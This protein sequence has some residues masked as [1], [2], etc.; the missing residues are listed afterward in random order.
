[1][2]NNNSNN[3]LKSP[4]PSIPSIPYFNKNYCIQNEAMI[5]KS[6][7][8]SGM[9]NWNHRLEGKLFFSLNFVIF[10]TLYL[11]REFSLFIK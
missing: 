5:K 3:H 11:K 10:N 9:P 1:M 2:D 4:M 8:N 6:I 7:T